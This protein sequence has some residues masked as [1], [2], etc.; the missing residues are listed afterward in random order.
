[1]RVHRRLLAQVEV[2][3]RAQTR[4]S[5]MVESRTHPLLP[6]AT[7]NAYTRDSRRSRISASPRR[8]E[9]S[10]ES[11]PPIPTKTPR[12]KDLVEMVRK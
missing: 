10:D 8:E 9:R 11:K 5:D 1:M 2:L 4:G 12:I 3:K 7:D 6:R